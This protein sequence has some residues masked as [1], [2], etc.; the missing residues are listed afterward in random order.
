MPNIGL[1]YIF[2]TVLLKKLLKFVPTLTE[3][4]P[5]KIP[6]HAINNDLKLLITLSVVSFM[7][8]AFDL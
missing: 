2:S 8:L 3:K 4:I 5:P 6:P 7:H 1:E